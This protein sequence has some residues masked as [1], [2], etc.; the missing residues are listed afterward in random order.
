[1]NRE[2]TFA[3]IMAGGIGSRFWP[4]STEENPKQFHDFLGTGKSLIRHTFDRLN[5]FVDADKILVITNKLYVDQVKE[6]IPQ[7]PEENVIGEPTRRNTAPCIYLGARF[8][9]GMDSDAQVIVAPADHLILEEDKFQSC[10]QLALD[11]AANENSFV[12]LGIEPSRPDTGYGYIEFEQ[13]DSEVKKVIQFREKPDRSTAEAFLKAGNFYWN[14]GIFIWNNRDLIDGIARHVSSIQ[15]A[16]S[17]V[18]LKDFEALEA[19]YSACPDI[20]ID[21]ALMEKAEKVNVVRGNF[22]WSDLGTWG[23]VY[24][25]L[26][27]DAFGNAGTTAE[28]GNS[29][30]NLVVDEENKKIVLESV[31]DLIV[32][33]TGKAL[34]ICHKDAEQEIKQIVARQ[35]KS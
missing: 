33:N 1:M 20:S 7:I 3:V 15:N 14:S 35:S 11:T 23:S 22:S 34:L 5:R 25:H 29:S 8:I 28:F 21:Y 24:Q 2:K 31:Q 9:E 30:G 18:D 17:S 32:I 13:N 12:T 19:G 6:H 27:K 10:I 26:E 4:F 16:L